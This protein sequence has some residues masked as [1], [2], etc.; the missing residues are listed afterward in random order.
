VF[1]E[2][3][4]LRHYSTVFTK[5]R[6][7]EYEGEAVSNSGSCGPC[8]YMIRFLLCALAYYV[9]VVPSWRVFGQATTFAGNAQHAS[10]YTAP[11]QN[12]NSIKWTTTI[13]HNNTGALAHYGSPLVTN[14]NTVLIPVKTLNDGFRVDAFNGAT[15]AFK[16][17]VM[18]DYRLPA[19][20]W[21]PTYNPCIATGDF[22]TRMYYAGAGGT[23]WHIDNVD[24]NMPTSPVRDV[25]YTSLASYNANATNYNNTIFVN[26]PL[27]A[28]F[29]GNVYFGFRIQGTAPAPLNTTQ[30]GFARIDPAGNGIYVL[31]GFAANDI[32]IDLD[33]HNVAPALDNNE[34]TIYVVAKSSSLG[35]YAY[36]L[37][38]K[39]T[40]LETKFSILLRDPR[41]GNFAGVPDNGTAS[42]MVAPDGDV[43]FGVF[44]NPNNGSR[45]FLLH[46]NADLSITKTP[47]AFGW[48]YT[49]GIVPAGMVPSYTGASSYL[50]FCKY[51]D[52]AFGDGTGVNRVALLDPTETQLDPHATAPGLVEMRE[53]L[54]VIGPTP[55]AGLPAFPNAVK[56]WC[57]NAPAVN[58]ATNAVLFDNEDGH[59]YHWNLATNSLDQ[60]VALT[61]GLGQPYVPT[62]IGPDGTVYSLNGGNFF[63][64]GSTPGV[65]ITM[66]SSSQD[67]RNTVF[68]DSIT[69]TANVSSGPPVPTG[70]ITFQDL[71]NNGTTPVVTTLAA[72]VPLSANGQASFTTS[73]L[74]AGGSNLG[75]HFITATYNGDQNHPTS[76]MTMV[77]KVHANAST[78]VLT[79]SATASM[80]G[81][82]VTFTATTSAVPLAAG[83]P[84]GMVTFQDGRTVIGQVPLNGSG[85]ASITKSDLSAGGHAIRASYVSDTK[86]A[87]SSGSLVQLVQNG[88]TLQLSQ[89]TLSVDEGVGTLTVTVA[90]TGNASA[91][92]TVEYKTLDDPAAV[93]C[94]TIN[95]TAYAR[96][97]YATT[98]D[99][100][101]FAPGETTKTFSIPLVNDAFVEGSETFMI[102]LSNP[103]G[104]TLGAPAT[105]TVAI[106]DNETVNGPNPI[107]STPFFV[108]QHYL[109]FLSR[110]PEAGE[111]WTALLN[112]CSD[113]NNNPACDRL[114]VSA[115]FFGSPEFQLKGYFVYRFHKLAFNR[116]PAYTE[117]ASEMRMVTGQTPQEVFQKKAAFTAGFIQQTEFANTYNPLTNPQ[118][119]TTLMGR[120]GLMQITTPDPAAPDGLTKITFTT[121][122]L[123]NRLSGIGGTLTRAQVLRAIADS[124]QVFQ[125][126]FNQAFVA[127][128]YYGYLRRTPETT[129]YTAWLNYLNSNPGDFRTMVNGFMNS[130]EYRLRFGP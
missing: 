47:G 66:N 71:S 23:I 123:S 16:Y 32:L 13:D 73:S 35:N 107:F 92:A 6:F 95:G 121:N 43:Y 20:N 94:D 70:T 7:I 128:Q 104:A 4:G 52:Y 9:C 79:S 100:L 84:T 89:H 64:L 50:L 93:R 34:S 97:D 105:A 82:A 8:N 46:F 21:I 110:E 18:S 39:P 48:D 99:T 1:Q 87:A 12:L 11:A 117:I 125:A 114:T 81:Q 119:V 113:L 15:P 10:V 91:A 28:D 29:A 57:I 19:H 130:V 36:L 14:A 31:A 5:K 101:T 102:A 17:S 22:G 76:S 27:T 24:T 78:T 74:A 103:T 69:F 56:E 124:D 59:M 41:N 106:S 61:A 60:A 127:M 85:V 53:V 77:Q 2:S 49:A 38:L 63:A 51:N 96:C 45:G 42:P 122:D 90:R 126:E 58:P 118:Y 129:G 54:T 116:L 30:S 62:V 37:G 112:G 44:A 25:F 115:A 3:F 108:R 67:L 109:D 26:T 40:T 75:N 86:F 88:V 120:Y 83:T 55:D 72:N 33:S 98:E 68:G 111:P 80:S 65:T